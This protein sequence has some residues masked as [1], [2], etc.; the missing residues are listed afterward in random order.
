MEVSRQFHALASLLARQEPRYPLGKTW[1]ILQ[2]VS[3]LWRS[4]TRTRIEP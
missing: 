4:L 1:W 3:V 2:L